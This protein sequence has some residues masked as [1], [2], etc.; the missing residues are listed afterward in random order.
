VHNALERDMDHF[1]KECACLFHDR[2]SGGHLSLSF[3]IQIKHCVNIA[4]QRALAFVI[5]RKIGL[6]GDVCFRPPI[7]IR[8][9]Y[10]LVGDIRR[11]VGEIASYHNKD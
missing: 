3:Y 5:E 9:H 11:V 2:Q 8:S 6:V 7:I 10:S 4:F 1:I